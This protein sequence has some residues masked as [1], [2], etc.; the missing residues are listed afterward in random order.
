VIH[1]LYTDVLNLADLRAL[2]KLP[3]PASWEKLVGRRLD[4]HS[5]ENWDRRTLG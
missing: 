2:S 4:S 5:L 3:L 1:L